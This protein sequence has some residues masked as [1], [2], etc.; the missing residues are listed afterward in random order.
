MTDFKGIKKEHCWVLR[1][2]GIYSKLSQ[3]KIT[4]FLSY[5]VLIKRAVKTLAVEV[6][7]P[8]KN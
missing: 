1:V 8:I 4:V 7:G 3:T 5:F 6:T 2:V